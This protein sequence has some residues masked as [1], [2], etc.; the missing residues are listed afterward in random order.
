MYVKAM[1]VPIFHCPLVTV[2]WSLSAGLVRA[3]DTI[4]ASYSATRVRAAKKLRIAS[5]PR[6]A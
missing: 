1:S 5:A 4:F 2:R 6:A 3:Y